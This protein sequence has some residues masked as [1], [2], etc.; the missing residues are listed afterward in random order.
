VDDKRT[1]ME[2]YAN[3]LAQ[4]LIRQKFAAFYIQ[5][6]RPQLST[7]VGRLPEAANLR[8]RF[9]RYID[10]PR[11]AEQAQGTVNHILD[12]GYAHLLRVLDPARTVITV[13]DII[14]ILAGQGK[15]PGVVLPR[16][17]RLSEYSASFLKKAA[18]IIAISQNTKTDLINY[19]GCSPEKISVIYY[20]LH[21]DFRPFSKEEQNTFCHKLGL[22]RDDT[23]LILIT[24]AQFYKNQQT[25]LHVFEKL[26]AQSS[27]PVKLLRLGRKSRDWDSLMQISP[28]RNH[29]I[30][31]EYLAPEDMV[32]LYNTV[33]CLLFP[34]WYEGFGWP[35]VEAMACGTPV[36]VS[37]RASLPEAVGDA[38]LM[39]EPDDID[40]LAQAVTRLLVDHNFREEQIQKGYKHIQRFNWQENAQRTATVYQR[41]ISEKFS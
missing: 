21:A 15:I 19:C 2:V 28:A 29:I 32:L 23:R 31:L 14:P 41:I 6:H 39:C 11:Q 25:S 13:H 27:F 10:Y 1:S 5:E 18:H 8:M 38:A 12:H 37:N 33:D 26:L 35:P 16:R 34:S 36:V 24:G 17:S 20:G 3:N 4:Q 30:H 22:P 40:A 7:L 9:A